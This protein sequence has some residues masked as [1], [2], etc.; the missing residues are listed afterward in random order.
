MLSKVSLCFVPAKVSLGYEQPPSW[1]GGFK[2]ACMHARANPRRFSRMTSFI[3]VASPSI[4]I[5]LTSVSL[6]I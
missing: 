6:L 3:V 1:T 5:Q 4:A 2:A